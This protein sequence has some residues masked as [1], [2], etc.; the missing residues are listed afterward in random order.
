MSE[1]SA[2]QEGIEL[3][4][5][6]LSFLSDAARQMTANQAGADASAA[7]PEGRQRLIKVRTEMAEWR[8]LLGSSIR[9]LA[10]CDR[11]ID[12]ALK[13]RGRLAA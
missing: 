5:K 2:H 12:R 11:V 10:E 13:K 7:T 4:R 3:M 8:A 9:D 6:Q 1:K